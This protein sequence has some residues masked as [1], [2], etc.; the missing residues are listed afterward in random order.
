MSARLEIRKIN[1]IFL[2]DEVRIQPLR[3]VS[4]TLNPGEIISVQGSSGSG[5][6]TLLLIMGA[7]LQPESGMLVHNDVSIFDLR[8]E[9][10]AQ[11]R[12]AEIGF[13]FQ[14]F[15]LIPYLT[16]LDNILIPTL[17]YFSDGAR[18]RAELL[19]HQLG[20]EKRK[21]HLPT[22]LS[23]GEKQRTALARALLNNPAFLLADE[24]TGNLDPENSAIVLTVLKK[25]AQDGGAV[26][27][28]TH[29]PSAAKVADRQLKLKNGELVTMQ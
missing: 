19:I 16:V 18:E 15:Y 9:E 21:Q 22:E 26:L 8:A 12:A 5:K 11:F 1:K 14:Q 17:T 4:L 2:K 28:V 13:I 7:L 20:L 3:E 23:A 27:L 29:D 25:Y 24:I 10:R 6:T